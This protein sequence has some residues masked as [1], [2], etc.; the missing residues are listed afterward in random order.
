VKKI[1]F[2][3]I[4]ISL[5]GTLLKAQT[6]DDAL[7]YAKPNGI[8][9]ARTAGLGV[10]Y[11]GVLD[12]MGT[13]FYNPAGLALISMTEL[14]L[15]FGY[16]NNKSQTDYLNIV[17]DFAV[18]KGYISNI[19]LVT[20]V[21]GASKN[22]ALGI[23]YFYESSFNGT[24]EF[25]VY[26]Q[27]S[28]IIAN[29]TYNGPQR[30][31]DNWAYELYLADF[32]G[33]KLV[34][35]YNGD[36]QQNNYVEQTGGIHNLTGGFGIELSDYLALGLSINTKWGSFHYF[37]DYRETD[38]NNIH[39]E[40]IDGRELKELRLVESYDS[41]IFGISGMLGLQAKIDKFMRASI[42]IQL[43]TYY[44]F[45][46]EFGKT[47]YADFVDGTKSWWRPYP[48]ETNP[49]TYSLTTPFIY[50]AGL[51][52]NIVGLTITAGI[53]YCD[54]TQLTFRDA[55][56]ELTD[57]NREIQ[58]VLTPQTKY[59]F[60]LEYQIPGIPLT[61]RGNYE[62]ASTPYKDNSLKSNYTNLALGAGVILG[63]NIRLDAVV[64]WSDYSTK[65]INYGYSDE[66]YYSEYTINT[67]PLNVSLG[68]TYRY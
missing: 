41:D 47:Y 54:V 11:H 21:Y 68:L 15:G 8:I 5:T 17:N 67:T 66:P 4:F 16:E 25:D 2:I 14:S 57:V 55:A 26:N 44:G 60:G 13:L 33:D 42:G 31:Y 6:V 59:G 49:T 19:G 36:M 64:R 12:D 40:T 53:E 30:E 29:E 52:G 45:N 35:N 39:Q 61:I 38:K 58:R 24:Q 65:G 32:Q 18:N 50:S 37:R 63:G 34:T 51:S 10:S 22:A 28:S 56:T 7:R 27:N 46:E 1:V 43:P 3:L 9:T 62:N 20:P 23:G 48:D